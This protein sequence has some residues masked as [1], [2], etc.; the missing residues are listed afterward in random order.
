[1]SDN[2][3]LINPF[4]LFMDSSI[5]NTYQMAALQGIQLP[6]VS[7]PNFDPTKMKPVDFRS[8]NMQLLEQQT[9]SQ[10][11]ASA[12][13]SQRSTILEMSTMPIQ[14]SYEQYQQ[15]SNAMNPCLGQAGW[16]SLINFSL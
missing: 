14:V 2:N 15:L 1:M 7:A 9:Q 5:T 11:S 6:F 10:Q 13:T 16:A 4:R 3:Y 8:D 12:E